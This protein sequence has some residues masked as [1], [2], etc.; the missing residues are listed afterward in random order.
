MD[1]PASRIL[2]IQLAWAQLVAGISNPILEDNDTRL[3]HL[4]NELWTTNLISSSQHH[5]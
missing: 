3:P 1:R 5:S 2:R 4:E